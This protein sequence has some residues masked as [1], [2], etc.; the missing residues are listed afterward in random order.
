MDHVILTVP[1]PSDTL[2]LECTNPL[3]P[4]NYPHTDIAGHQCLLITPEGGKVCRV[5]KNTGADDS[6]TRC[7]RIDIDDAGNGKAHIKTEY[8][9]GAYEGMQRFVHN[10]SRDEQINYL[11][12]DLR[13]SKAR[14]GDLQIRPN[15]S[16]DPDLQLEYNADVERFANKSGNRLFVPFSL[17]QPIFAPMK[18]GKRTR[19]II[20]PGDIL[21]TDTVQMTIPTGYM[22][23]SIPNLIKDVNG[24]FGEYS[25]NIRSEGNTI[26]VI[27]RIHIKK[28]RY[29]ASAADDFR[30]FFKNMEKEWGRRAVFKQRI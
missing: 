4:F 26:Y 1:M 18:S 7:I 25:V 28:G 20:L 29:P 5:R 30:T 8:K 17:L 24:M 14:I 9:S 2:W 27:Q 16:E 13:M 12:S 23:E 21:R 22:P 11:A 15:D 10:M 6:K 19:D 3:L